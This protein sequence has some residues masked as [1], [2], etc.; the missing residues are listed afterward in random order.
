MTSAQAVRA[1][2]GACARARP[3]TSDCPWL[4]IRDLAVAQRSRLGLVCEDGGP[5]LRRS[6]QTIIMLWQAVVPAD[7]GRGERT[8][9]RSPWRVVIAPRGG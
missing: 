8:A 7:F 2:H 4:T 1:V 3:P 6:A 5:V 9:R